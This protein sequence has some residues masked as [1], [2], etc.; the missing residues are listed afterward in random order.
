MWSIVNVITEVEHE[1]YFEAFSVPVGRKTYFD[2]SPDSSRVVYSVCR[3]PVKTPEPLAP[4][5]EWYGSP[6]ADYQFEIETANIDGSGVQ[7]LTENQVFDNYPAWSPDGTRI[8]FIWNLSRGRW[9]VGP[10]M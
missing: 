9:S 5:P 7:V 10:C 6:V 4:G 8:A 2:V 3:L 1:P